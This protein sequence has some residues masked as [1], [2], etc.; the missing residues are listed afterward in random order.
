M[1]KDI[2]GKLF[3]FGDNRYG[4]L[5]VINQNDIVISQPV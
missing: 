3:V 1:L 4:Q 5:G 2:N